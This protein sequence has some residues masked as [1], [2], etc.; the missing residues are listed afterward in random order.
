L[1]SYSEKFLLVTADVAALLSSLWLGQ[2]VY[3]LLDGTALADPFLVWVSSG[4]VRTPFLGGLALITVVWF[5]GLGHYTRRR[6]FWDELLETLRVIG[7]IAIMDAAVVFVAGWQLS[8]LWLLVTWCSAAVLVPLFRTFLKHWLILL[9]VWQRPTVI[10][11]TGENA[12]EAATA[13]SSE[14]LLGLNIVAFLRPGDEAADKPDSI[15]LGYRRIPV[16]SL[17]SHP[18]TVLNDLG[19]PHVVVALEADSLQ[20]ERSLIEQLR[21]LCPDINVVPPLHGLP[22]FSFEV[23]H[24]I[25]HD[26]LFLG[27]PSNLSRRSSRY[28]K[29]LFDIL[30]ASILLLVL[31]PLLISVTLLV[32]GT[33][34]GGILYKHRRIGRKGEPFT[35][36]KFRTMVVGADEI[37][38]GILASDPKARTEWESNYKLKND[39]RV[40]PL[41][42][43]LR[44]LSLDE[45]P[46]LWNVLKGDMSLV[47]PRPIVAAE[48]VR[49]GD[50]ASDYLQSGPGITGLWQISGRND[51]SYNSRVY[52][53]TWYAKN[54]SL[55]FDVV[56]LLRTFK[57]VVSGRGAY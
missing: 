45:L 11:G 40:T 37:L 22:L 13:L 48:L 4:D 31:S 12:R 6:P 43:V 44:K 24:F 14:P 50:H 54:W 46:Q 3:S 36:Y 52:L 35:C 47:G 17:G 30:G 5:W 42:H 16:L 19:R 18:E 33:T 21:L 32:L 25:S 8:R 53:D 51:L 34:G 7:I 38:H 10:V 20:K 49:Y 55:W 23:S 26:V 15:E 41:G 39:P 29:R 57:A 1:S 27:L 9:G 56:I 28:A 2:I